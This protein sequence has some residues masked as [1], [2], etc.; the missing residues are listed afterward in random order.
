[1]AFGKLLVGLL[2]FSVTLTPGNERLHALEEVSFGG[3]LQFHLVMI[4]LS[5]A[6]VD[7]CRDLSGLIVKGVGAGGKER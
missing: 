7:G 1:M 2:F 5:V 4:G 3:N 6:V